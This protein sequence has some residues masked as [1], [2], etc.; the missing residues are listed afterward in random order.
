M[1]DPPV[2]ELSEPKDD[3]VRLK[4]SSA[5]LELAKAEAAETAEPPTFPPTPPPRTE[6]MELPV[7]AAAASAE[8]EKADAREEV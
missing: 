4:R 1:S 2:T 8:G 7:A 5:I 6:E 3:C